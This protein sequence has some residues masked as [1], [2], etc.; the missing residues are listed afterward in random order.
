M[1][2]LKILILSTA[3]TGNTWLRNLLSCIYRLPQIVL[4]AWPFDPA[5]FADAGPRWIT[6]HHYPPSKALLDWINDNSIFL[7]TTIRHPADTL[8]SLYHHI[9]KFQKDSVDPGVLRK[10]LLEDFPRT[11]VIPARVGAP[12]SWGLACS[13]EWMRSGRP[14]VVRYEDL[15][16]NTAGVLAQLMSRI[17][18]VDPDRIDA[19]IEACHIDLMRNLAGPVVPTVR[20]ERI[21][22]DVRLLQRN[23]S[24]VEPVARPKVGI[25]R[26]GVGN[27]GRSVSPV[28]V[29]HGQRRRT[30][31]AAGRMSWNPQQR[32]EQPCSH[33][34]R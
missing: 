8:I 13:I 9:H 34:C 4:T 1:D 18:P 17:G 30:P 5:A 3:K 25:R 29:P 14:Y 15:R 10:M 33:Y 27:K 28:S 32:R 11:D 2:D 23:I 21:W 24:G 31:A 26:N 19:A 6:H 20:R 12:F 7:I 16:L 22:S